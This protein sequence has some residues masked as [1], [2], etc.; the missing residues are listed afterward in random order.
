MAAQR[1]ELVAQGVSVR[2]GRVQVLADLD[3]TVRSGDAPAGLVGE[4]ATGKS[5]M[6]RALVGQVKA[7]RGQI[8][9][10][11]RK[12]T[13]VSPRDK[14]FRDSAVRFIAQNGAFDGIESTQTAEKLIKAAFKKARRAGRE[15]GL[16]AK[17]MFDLVGL[18]SHDADRPVH[19]ISGGQRQRAALAVALA[20]RPRILILDE[21]VTALDEPSRR[22]V[23]RD[24]LAWCADEGTGILLISHDLPLLEQVTTTTHVLAEGKIVESGPLRELMASPQH[25]VTQDLATALP[26]AYLTA[27]T[28]RH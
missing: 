17:T 21:P 3:F 6:A 12:I 28:M 2:Q 22:A 9:L 15:S 18:A 26:K 10:N 8:T 14:K 24:V 5:T 1:D 20:T 16:D 4:S 25:Q 13:S 27:G 19:Y 11:G 7:D 23:M